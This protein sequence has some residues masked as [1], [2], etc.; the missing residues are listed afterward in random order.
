MTNH[1]IDLRNTDVFMVCGSNPAE[2]HPVSW[3]W[4]EEAREKRGAKIIVVDPRF[5]RSASRADAFSFIRPGTDIVFYGALINYA[6]DNNYINWEYVQ[7]YTN[8][9]VMVNPDFK[10]PGELDGLF[11]GYNAETRKYDI[12]TWSYQA[13]PD[14]QPIRVDLVPLAPQSGLPQP[15]RPQRAQGLERQLHPQR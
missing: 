13:G 12:K 9:P 15:G 6:I 4:M 3:K 14:G 5:T 7:N 8:A 11:S 10:G 2:N 1:W